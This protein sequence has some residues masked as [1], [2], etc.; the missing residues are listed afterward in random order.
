MKDKHDVLEAELVRFQQ[1]LDESFT[2]DDLTDAR[3]DGYEMCLESLDG[4][5]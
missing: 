2:Q 4:V 3:R 5:M 1:L